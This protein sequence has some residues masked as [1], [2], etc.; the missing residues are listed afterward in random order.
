MRIERLSAE[1]LPESIL[2]N[3]EASVNSRARRNDSL[4]KAGVPF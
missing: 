4:R 1:S 2:T 3:K